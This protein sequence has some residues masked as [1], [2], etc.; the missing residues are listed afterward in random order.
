MLCRHL[1]HFAMEER[2][3]VFRFSAPWM[4]CLVLMKR[5]RLN[6]ISKSWSNRIPTMYSPVNSRMLKNNAF[7]LA[8]KNDLKKRSELTAIQRH[9]FRRL[10]LMKTNPLPFLRDFIRVVKP[11]HSDL[12]SASLILKA[13]NNRHEDFNRSPINDFEP[14]IDVILRLLKKYI[15]W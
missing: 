2:W 7:H 1:Q 3:S 8:T 11:M 4:K 10:Q 15:P 5:C 9:N 6:S 13:H 12:I 14:T